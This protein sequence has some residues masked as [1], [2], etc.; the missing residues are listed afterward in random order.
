MPG[1]ITGKGFVKGDKRI[2]RHGRPRS[3]DAL[4]KLAQKIANETVEKPDGEDVTRIE[5]MLRNMVKSKVP[6]DR[7][8]FLAYSYGKPHEEIDFHNV[9][10]S[11]MTDHQLER[12]KKGDN[13]IDVLADK[14]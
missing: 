2:N 11:K 5:D 4:R 1:G 13:L 7:A 9:D 8:T 10:L 14:G 3:F 6:A 12:I